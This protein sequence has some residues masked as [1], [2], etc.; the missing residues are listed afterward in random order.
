MSV[1]NYNTNIRI[2]QVYIYG[3]MVCY[4]LWRTFTPKPEPILLMRAEKH[5]AR[6]T[7]APPEKQFF[8]YF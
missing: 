1:Y 7:P 2:I 5:K 6:A 8:D 3:V 4:K